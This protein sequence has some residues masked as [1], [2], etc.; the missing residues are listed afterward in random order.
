M[1]QDSCLKDRSICLS[2]SSFASSLSSFMSP[3][4]SSLMS[5]INSLTSP[6]ASPMSPTASLISPIAF[7]MSLGPGLHPSYKVPFENVAQLIL[8]ECGGVDNVHK[9]FL[10][11]D[12]NFLHY[13]CCYCS[14]V[15]VANRAAA[16]L[17]I[18]DVFVCLWIGWWCFKNS[19]SNRQW[20][21]L[22]VQAPGCLHKTIP[23]LQVCFS[24]QHAQRERDRQRQRPRDT[25]SFP[26]YL[27]NKLGHAENWIQFCCAPSSTGGFQQHPWVAQGCWVCWLHSD[28]FLVGGWFQH[29]WRSNGYAGNIHVWQNKMNFCGDFMQ[30]WRCRSSGK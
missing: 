3:I 2:P 22:R 20:Q 15:L 18:F 7:L 25:E 17:A 1:W 29:S 11:I 24:W 8:Q 14:P 6:V 27:C 5:L 16:L 12:S 9:F 19:A 28:A 4:A 30:I 26:T 21:V 13:C 23:K 10:L